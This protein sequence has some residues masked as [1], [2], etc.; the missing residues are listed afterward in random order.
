L[1]L[2]IWQIFQKLPF[3][4]ALH[5]PSRFIIMFVFCISIL[6][7]KTLSDIKLPKKR[8]A[9]AIITAVVAIDLLLVSG[10]IMS[11]AFD[12]EP[13]D[14]NTNEYTDYVQVV[15]ENPYISQ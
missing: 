15:V 4:G 11:D 6:A 10:P 9:T 1:R 8:I 2:A 14:I 13:V 3:L 5:G 12:V 7:A